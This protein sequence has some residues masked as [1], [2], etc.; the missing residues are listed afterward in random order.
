M[1]WFFVKCNADSLILWYQAFLRNCLVFIPENPLSCLY[2]LYFLFANQFSASSLL[3]A[4]KAPALFA[5]IG[6]SSVWY[7][8]AENH[9]K[10]FHKAF[11][12]GM[13]R[14]FFSMVFDFSA[15]R[16]TTG[17][18]ETLLK[19]ERD[20]TQKQKFGHTFFTQ[21]RYRAVD[22]TRRRKVITPHEWQKNVF[23]S[24]PINTSWN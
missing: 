3:D 21:T 2:N 4:I 10:A 22:L 7:S 15:R 9:C 12:C 19:R 11:C 13:S 23:S 14:L 17:A 5:W 16:N 6:W 1:C 8:W 24:L 20:C 18:V